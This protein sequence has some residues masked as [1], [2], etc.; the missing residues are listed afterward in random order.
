MLEVPHEGCGI[1]EVDGGDTQAGERTGIGDGN[2]SLIEY[3]FG[4]WGA[5]R[6]D[7]VTVCLD[8]AYLR[9]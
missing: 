4:P 8:M 5:A 2:H 6:E 7:A 1:E 9:G 3:Q